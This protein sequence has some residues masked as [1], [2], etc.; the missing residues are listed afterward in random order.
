MHPNDPRHGQLGGYKAG[1]RQQCCRDA[2]NRYNQGRK[3]TLT[4]HQIPTLLHP[5]QGTRRRIQALAALGWSL[6]ALQPHTGTCATYLRRITRGE[7]TRVE[8]RTV[9]RIRTAYDALSMLPPPTGTAR[10]KQSVTRTLR[11]AAIR[12]WV[13]PLAWDDI[14][15][16]PHPVG[17]GRDR[18]WAAADLVAEYEWLARQGYT[19]TTAAERLGITKEALEKAIER[20]PVKEQAA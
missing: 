9:L 16:D 4:R 14:D 11:L 3:L 17:H 1:C 18:N 10:E 13:P 7:I 5:A 6:A 20:T 19:R 12:G 15:H 8:A 2:I